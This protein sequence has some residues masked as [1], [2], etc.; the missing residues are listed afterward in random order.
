MNMDMDIFT[1]NLFVGI[2]PW[3]AGGVAWLLGWFCTK[4]SGPCLGF[5]W[6][7]GGW[8]HSNYKDVCGGFNEGLHQ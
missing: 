2:V 5:Q 8:A 4:T 3:R 6:R 1:L 7:W